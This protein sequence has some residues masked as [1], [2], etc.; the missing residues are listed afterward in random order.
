MSKNEHRCDSV[1]NPMDGLAYRCELY[2]G[3]DES[4]R[5]CIEWEEE[6]AGDMMS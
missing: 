6:H 5:Y 3:H 4:H 1:F 2:E